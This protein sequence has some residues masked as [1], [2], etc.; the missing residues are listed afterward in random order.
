MGDIGTLFP[1][2]ESR[3]KDADSKE[4]LFIV[5]EKLDAASIPYHP[6]NKGGIFFWVDLRAYLERVKHTDTPEDPLS[7]EAFYPPEFNDPDEGKLTRYLR[8]KAQVLLIRGQ[9]CFWSE[10]GW[11][12]LCYTAETPDKVSKGLDSM[13]KKLN[14]LPPTNSD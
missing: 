1:S 9:E 3:W 11:F 14:E 8:E 5:K 4:L 10:P 12:R 13:I 2:T 6:N 7:C